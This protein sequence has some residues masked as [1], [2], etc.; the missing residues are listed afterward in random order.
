MDLPVETKLV[1]REEIVV[2]NCQKVLINQ[3]KGLSNE[4]IV[5]WAKVFAVSNCVDSLPLMLEAASESR[6]ILQLTLRRASGSKRG[7]SRDW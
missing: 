4:G 2:V 6:R 5:Q 1:V 7:L 3:S